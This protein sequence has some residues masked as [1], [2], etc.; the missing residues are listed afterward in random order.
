MSNPIPNSG[1]YAT[2]TGKE[3]MNLIER[4][5]AEHRSTAIYIYY[6]TL[7]LCHEL[8]N[9]AYPMGEGVTPTEDEDGITDTNRSKV[10]NRRPDW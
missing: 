8:V 5:P 9:E 3:V 6:G 10:V 2:L 1:W 7:N 4:M